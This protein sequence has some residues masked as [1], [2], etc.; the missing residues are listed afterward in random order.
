MK[1]RLLVGPLTCYSGV[2]MDNINSARREMLKLGGIGLAA[3]AVAAAPSAFAAA[4]KSSGAFPVGA[5]FDIR[6]YGAVGDGKT[7]CS[8]AINK[9][10]DAAAAA[11]GGTVYF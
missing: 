9:A 4:P 7:V 11:G 6:T 10:I 5:I 3:S 1:P 8:P 2:P